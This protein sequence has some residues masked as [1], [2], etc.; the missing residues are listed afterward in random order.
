MKVLSHHR[1]ENALERVRAEGR[2]VAES[3]RG[4]VVEP[5]KEEV[6][7]MRQQLEE[8]QAMYEVNRMS[9]FGVKTN[10]R[11]EQSGGYR[12][13]GTDIVSFSRDWRIVHGIPA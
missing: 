7:R 5:L 10:L 13:P 12:L 3:A 1:H 4:E 2:S 11:S 8:A 6:E 9:I